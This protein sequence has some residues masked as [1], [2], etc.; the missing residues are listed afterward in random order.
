VPWKP[1]DH[2]VYG[3]VEIGG[4]QQDFVIQNPP[5]KFLEQELEKVTKFAIVQGLMSPLVRV[6]ETSSEDLGDGIFRVRASVQNQGYLPTA[7]E[8]AKTL[9]LA[10]PVTVALDGG[11]VLSE[12][13]THALGTLTGWGPARSNRP[14]YNAPGAPVHGVS[15]I[16]RGKAGDPLT[17]EVRSERGGRH[18]VQ[19]RLGR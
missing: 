7:L 18:Q 4:L 1:Y 11:E 3:E 10:K 9:G 6:V 8:R 19:M 2:P 12:P 16:V 14:S 15:W 13:T 5:P 17:V